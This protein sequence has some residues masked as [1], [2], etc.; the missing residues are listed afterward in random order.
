MEETMVYA[1][2]IF[3]FHKYEQMLL[4]IGSQVLL[5]FFQDCLLSD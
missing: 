2:F 4:E 1:A 5:L 3:H